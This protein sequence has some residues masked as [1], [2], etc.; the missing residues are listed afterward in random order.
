M[1]SH[2]FVVPQGFM[3]ALKAFMKTLR[4]W[5]EVW[6]YKL[7]LIF[8]LRPG[9]GCEGLR[10]SLDIL[11]QIFHDTD[12]VLILLQHLGPNI[13]AQLFDAII[14]HWRTM[15]AFYTSWKRQKTWGIFRFSGGIEIEHW[16]ER[17]NGTFFKHSKWNKE[18]W[19][20]SVGP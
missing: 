20:F 1:F 19:T 3:G 17:W 4:H 15:L 5:K 6:K 18:K 7:K 11:L 13:S 8:S 10:F 14:S 16:P 2:F 12:K 9:L